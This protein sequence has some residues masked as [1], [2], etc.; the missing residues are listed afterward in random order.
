MHKSLELLVMLL[1]WL[2][3]YISFQWVAKSL[4]FSH[5]EESRFS[6]SLLIVRKKKG[7]LK[8]CLKYHAFMNHVKVG[9]NID[10]QWYILKNKIKKK[11]LGRQNPI[12]LK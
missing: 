3:G 5:E 8:S 12:K 7:K 6:S 9:V 10:G 4:K 11:D 1:M 2:E